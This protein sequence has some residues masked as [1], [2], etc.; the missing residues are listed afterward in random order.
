MAWSFTKVRPIIGEAKEDPAMKRLL[1]SVMVLGSAQAL[2]AQ[3]ETVNEEPPFQPA[4]TLS[5]TD[6]T[7]PI[8]SIASGVVVLDA[9]VSET[10][11]VQRVEVRRDIVS[12]TAPAVSAVQEWKFS[13]AKLAGRAIA[14]RVPVAVSVRPAG[15][16]APTPLPALIPKSESAIQAR[17]QPAEVL[18]AVFPNYPANN[19]VFAVTVVLEVTLSVTGKAENVNVLRDVPPATAEVVPVVGEWRFM[20]ATLNGHPVPSKVVLAFVLRPPVINPCW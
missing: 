6:I 20:P 19:V 1:L 4:E 3:T 7:I 14:S 8:R 5:I 2:I 15:Y 13:P 12:L 11:N 17:F 10:G 18:H 16:A 9:L